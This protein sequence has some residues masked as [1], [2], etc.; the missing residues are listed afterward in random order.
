MEKVVK[1][2]VVDDDRAMLDMIGSALS[3]REKY[4]VSLVLNSEMALHKLSNETFDTVISDINLPGMDGLD[5]LSRINII[6]PK[7]PVIL[8]TGF[9]EVKTMQ[10]AIK[11]G[12]YD[13]LRKPFSLSELQISVRQAV[14]KRALLIQNEE[15][16]QQLELLVQKK[17]S[18]LFD[19]NKLLEQNFIRTVLAMIN[20]LEA[21][22]IYTKGHSERVTNIS[23]LIG[24]AMNLSPIEIKTLRTGA[25]F[26]DLGKI[27]I[28]S[29]LLHKP[30]TLSIDELSLIKQHPIIGEKI[31]QPIALNK[32]IT[33][34]V[35]QHHERYDGKGYPLG[36]K[37]HDISLL[38]RIV[39]IADSYDAMTSSR[40]YR[41]VFSHAQ[42]Y[43]EIKKCAGTQ[44]DPMIVEYFAKAAATQN[45]ETLDTPS[46]DSILTIDM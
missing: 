23:L 21:S 1:I 6:D 22:D 27:G 4:E 34:I 42:A 41:D 46:L 40:S 19:A 33:N 16:T 17:A 5:L 38:A 36:L 43:E 44:F 20:A 35:V 29:A 26:H 14:Q 31:I 28:Y 13:F 10:T 24:Q 7:L 18:E 12:V 9:A 15:Y 37:D 3:S 25:I 11:L 32:E 8:I 2:L 45:F 30:A 39:T